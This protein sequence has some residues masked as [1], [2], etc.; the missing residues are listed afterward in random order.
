MDESRL[1]YL[2]GTVSLSRRQ[3]GV[4]MG[5]SK[6]FLLQLTDESVET[7]FPDAGPGCMDLKGET[8]NSRFVAYEIKGA[9]TAW[10]TSI[11]IH[12]VS[13]RCHKMPEALGNDC[14]NHC[15]ILLPIC[16]EAGTSNGTCDFWGSVLKETNL[17]RG[18]QRL[19]MVNINMASV[20]GRFQVEQKDLDLLGP[21]KAFQPWPAFSTDLERAQRA[22]R[23]LGK[24]V[25]RFAVS[26]VV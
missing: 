19:N 4:S 20:N 26:N 25:D 8:R 16:S 2:H 5:L 15:G 18:S 6:A 14:Q 22:F 13:T 7:G 9:K 23:P 10:R 1:H 21:S 12:V 24:M 3:P 11:L 17:D